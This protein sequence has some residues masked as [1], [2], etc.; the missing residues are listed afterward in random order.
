MQSE[1]RARSHWLILACSFVGATACALFAVA[2]IVQAA[3]DHGSRG[4]NILRVA[5]AIIFLFLALFL[6]A[7]GTLHRMSFDDDHS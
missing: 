2:L 7:I 6:I 4:G 5:L 3:F 1:G